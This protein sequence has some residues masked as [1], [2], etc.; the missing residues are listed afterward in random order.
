[1][2]KNQKAKTKKWKIPKNVEKK[3]PLYYN[4]NGRVKTMEEEKLK[5]RK[6]SYEELL[7][8]E[9]KIKDFCKA[10]ETDY[11]ETKAKGGQ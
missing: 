4:K 2:I 1:M 9:A 8:A 3:N 5:V 7:E 11:K 6:L 10:I